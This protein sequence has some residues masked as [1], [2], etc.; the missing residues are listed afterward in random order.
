MSCHRHISAAAVLNF[1][2]IYWACMC[3][4]DEVDVDVDVDLTLTNAF[5]EPTAFIDHR[6]ED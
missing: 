5:V 2:A 6:K 1:P 4:T 3:A